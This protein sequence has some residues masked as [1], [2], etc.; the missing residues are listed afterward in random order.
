MFQHSC[1]LMKNISG[2]EPVAEAST[3]KMERS[4][5]NGDVSVSIVVRLERAFGACCSCMFCE[6]NRNQVRISGGAIV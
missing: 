5:P 6:Q 4:L 2:A 1:V 3:I